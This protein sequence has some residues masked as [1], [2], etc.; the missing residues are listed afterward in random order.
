MRRAIVLCCTGALLAGAL[1]SVGV[2]APC[3]AH[4]V[5]PDAAEVEA[6]DAGDASVAEPFAGGKGRRSGSRGPML[7]VLRIAEALHLSDEQTIKLAAEFRRVAQ[8]RHELIARR[9]ALATRL[10]AQLAQRPLDDAA[11]TSLTEQLVALD[12]QI[13]RLPE[14]LWKSIQPVLTPE[15]SARLVLLRGKLKQQVDGERRTRRGKGRNGGAGGR[16]RD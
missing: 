12:Q 9:A 4:A 1:P 8:Q 15:Q 6:D 13:G 11:L 5:S 7:L 3:R 10:E 14:G 16:A 2:L